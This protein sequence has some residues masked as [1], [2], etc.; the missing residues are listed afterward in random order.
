MPLKPQLPCLPRYSTVTSSWTWLTTSPPRAVPASLG[1]GGR[2]GDEWVVGYPGDE[3]VTDIP[4][5]PAPTARV[6]SHGTPIERGLGGDVDIASKPGKLLIWRW[7]WLRILCSDI[8]VH[9]HVGK[10][11]IGQRRSLLR[12]GSV[13]G[14]SR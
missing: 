3:I 6:R 8:V 5:H 10:R 13:I 12:Q 1:L 7:L 14:H 2:H 4:S 11:I 9:T